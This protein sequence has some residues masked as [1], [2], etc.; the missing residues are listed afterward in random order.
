MGRWRLK[1]Q[2]GSQVSEVFETA[3]AVS[4]ACCCGSS[5]AE[6]VSSTARPRRVSPAHTSKIACCHHVAC[7]V[8]VQKH[9]RSVRDG[10]H[11]VLLSR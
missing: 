5:N 10:G 8:T 3:A 6:L 2:P 11:V 9:A 7:L 1:P 4:I